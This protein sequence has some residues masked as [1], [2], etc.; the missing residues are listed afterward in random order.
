MVSQLSLC[1]NLEACDGCDEHQEKEDLDGAQWFVEN[2]RL[3]DGSAEYSD[4]HPDGV[5]G[6]HREI[7]KRDCEQHHTC[8]DGATDNERREWF[9]KAV[10]E[11][12]SDRPTCFEQSSHD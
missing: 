8:D 3:R 5:S 12:E 4:A 6:S 10:S 11:F 7:A 1:C 9:R 2:K